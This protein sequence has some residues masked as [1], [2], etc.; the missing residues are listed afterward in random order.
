MPTIQKY[1]NKISMNS[2][3]ENKIKLQ[4]NDV[5][6][7]VMCICIFVFNFSTRN[8]S[9]FSSGNTMTNLVIGAFIAWTLLECLRKHIMVW[10]KIY[11]FSFLFL[12]LSLVSAIYAYDQ[13]DTFSKVQTLFLVV[14]LSLCAY[15]YIVDEDRIDFVLNV[16]VW[17]GT[18][19]AVYL[20]LNTNMAR[21]TRIGSVVGDANLVGISLATV[22]TI[23]LYLLFEDK[24][25]IH[26]LQVGVMGYVIL[27][28]GSRTA[29]AILLVSIVLIIYITAYINR[30]RMRN[31][32]LA[33]VLII[34]GG[35]TMERPHEN[36]SIL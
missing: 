30:W 13:G 7:S 1:G 29:L 34:V 11:T 12:F 24:R 10:N 32:I 17:S 33:T 14:L 6:F 26:I 9:I 4:I 36:S 3:S 31:V 19:C 15:K 25:K 18:L 28:T 35:S 27:L 2:Q 20:I 16:Y 21:T 5:L 22:A 8:I 23:A